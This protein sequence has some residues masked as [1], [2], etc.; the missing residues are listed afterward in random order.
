MPNL[1]AALCDGFCALASGKHAAINLQ[2]CFLCLLRH[3]LVFNSITAATGLPYK[4]NGSGNYPLAAII[5][6]LTGALPPPTAIPPWPLPAGVRSKA[7]HGA[8]AGRC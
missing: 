2:S 7:E 8:A 1:L 4:G 3:G 5:F 6:C